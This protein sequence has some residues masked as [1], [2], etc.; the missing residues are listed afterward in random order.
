MTTPLHAPLSTRNPAQLIAEAHALGVPA[1]HGGSRKLKRVRE[2]TSLTFVGADTQGRPQWLTPRTARAWTRMR[3]AAARDDITLE[4]VSAFRSVEYQL[5]I[6]Q[7]KV[8]RGLSM[9]EILLV[10]AAPGYS[11]HHSGRAFDLT[12]PNFAALEEE[13]EKSPAFAWL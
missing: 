4:I 8:E 12:T 2:A 5:G 11:E 6:I 13:F 10:S 3:D 7:R 1:N 9:E